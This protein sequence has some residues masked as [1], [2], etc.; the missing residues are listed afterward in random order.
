MARNLIG[1]AFCALVAACGGKGPAGAGDAAGGTAGVGAATTA[2]PAPAVVAGDPKAY[3]SF[4]DKNWPAEGPAALAWQ[5]PATKKLGTVDES[6][7]TGGSG[8]W[9]WISFWAT[10]CGPCLAEMPLLAKWRDGLQKDGV[11][12]DLE[13]W[14]I[15]EDE[16]ALR[17][18]L[19]A[20]MPAPVKWVTGP[21]ALQAFLT[22]VGLNADSAIPIQVLIDPNNKLRCVRVGSVHDDDWGTIRKLVGK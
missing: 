3:Q 2:P 19:K 17:E 13:L 22:S 7:A 5:G 6:T 11:A 21:A 9:K 10:W 8:R 15:D 20:G 14:S 4:C 12:M 18:K 16:V 1:M